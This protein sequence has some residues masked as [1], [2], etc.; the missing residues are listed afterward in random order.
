[1]VPIAHIVGDTVSIAAVC[2]I[3]LFASYTL[4]AVLDG[5]AR[6]FGGDND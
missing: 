2:A 5:V 4:L 3:G 6:W 1:M